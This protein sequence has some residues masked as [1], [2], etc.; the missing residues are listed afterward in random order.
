MHIW[1]FT[2][3]RYHGLAKNAERAFAASTSANLH[4]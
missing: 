4:A 2:R 1:G 3:V